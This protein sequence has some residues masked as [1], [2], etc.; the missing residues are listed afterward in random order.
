[1]MK[2]IKNIFLI[3]LL[4]F[5]FACKEDPIPDPM[6]ETPL[7]TEKEKEEAPKL[8]QDINGFIKTAMTDIYLWYRYLPNIDIKYEMDSKAYFDKLLYDEDKWSF[9]TD[10]VKALES[11]FEGV[12]TSFG[13]SLAFG[14]FS[15]TGNIF[16]LVEFVYPNTPAAEAGLKR[17]DIIVKMSGSDITDNNYRD[18]LYASSLTISLGILG[19]GGISVDPNSVKMTAEEL[20]LDPVMITEIIEHEGTRVGYLFYAQFIS[21]FNTSL[22]TAFQFFQ[23]EGITDLI[24]DF[25]YN[26]GGGV[27]AAQY[28]CSSVAPVNVVNS[29]STLVTYQWNDK[30][31]NY[32]KSNRRTDQIEVDFISNTKV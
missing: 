1:M 16:A 8:T 10:D 22:D 32:W 2:L 31:Q 26:P 21:N 13:Y 6:P 15:N 11:S 17:G 30:Y 23:N 20:T 19:E 24:L 7:D 29:N 9:I 28:L 5:A 18:L 4:A 14:R 25:R 27:N 3:L 12:E